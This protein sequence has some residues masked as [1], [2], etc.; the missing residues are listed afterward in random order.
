ME[1]GRRCAAADRGAARL[2]GIAAFVAASD[3]DDDTT[4]AGAAG[5]A[6][7]SGPQQSRTQ[8]Q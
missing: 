4:N 2:D 6:A 3:G 7:T 1:G 5:V 8:S